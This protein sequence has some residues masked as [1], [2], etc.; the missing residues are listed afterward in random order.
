MFDSIQS[1][2]EDLTYFIS[3]PTNWINN[4]ADFAIATTLANL[5]GD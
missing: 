5:I 4:A 1:N 3:A 2:E